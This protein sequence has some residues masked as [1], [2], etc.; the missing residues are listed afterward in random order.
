[1]LMP[2]DSEGFGLPVAEA[3]ACGTVVL[4]SDIGVLREV[5]GETVHYA[6]VG[7]VDCWIEQALELLK[8]RAER[9]RIARH[10]TPS[11]AEHV[12]QLVTYYRR[13]VEP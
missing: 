3:L 5:G 2:S 13:L 11:W 7:D 6:P 8:R 9:S 12:E 10:T 1:M 4:A